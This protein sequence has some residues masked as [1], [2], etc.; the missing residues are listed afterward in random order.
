MQEQRA[1]VERIVGLLAS[2]I[3]ILGFFIAVTQIAKLGTFDFDPQTD[4]QPIIGSLLFAFITVVIVA[5]CFGYV[6]GMLVAALE[7]YF[8]R[9][10]LVFSTPIL[11]MLSAFQTGVVTLVISSTFEVT[12]GFGL[13]LFVSFFA[14]AVLEIMFVFRHCSNLFADKTPTKLATDN[15][16]RYALSISIVNQSFFVLGTLI[17]LLDANLI[18]SVEAIFFGSL[19]AIFFGF[20]T[21]FFGLGLFEV[22]KD[23]ERVSKP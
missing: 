14:S 20:V 3:T 5:V 13:V 10:A 6:F 9:L 19:G 17:F 12:S 15:Y 16:P 11:G 2:L 7:L 1:S 8:G 22:L 23:D 4:V 18:E 21:Y